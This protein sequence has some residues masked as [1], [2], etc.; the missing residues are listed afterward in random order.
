ML[1][2]IKRPQTGKKKKKNTQTK[3]IK[4]QLVALL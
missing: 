4:T 3:Q 1:G 2:K